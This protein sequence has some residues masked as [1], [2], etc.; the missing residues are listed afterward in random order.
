MID[1]KP[2]IT[3]MQYIFL[4]HGVQ[5]GIGVLTLPRKL[6]DTAGTDGW[7]TIIICW[8]LATIFSLVIIQVM[9]KYPNGTIIDLVSHYFGKW[10]GKI[11]ALIFALYFGLLTIITYI[12]EVLFIQMWIL[13]YSKLFVLVLLIAVPSYFILRN[14]IHILGR[15][16]QFIF[17]MTLWLII[18]Y[19]M[20]LKYANWLHLLPILKEGWTPVVNGLKTGVFSF[21]GYEIAFFLYPYLEQKEKASLGIVI[22]NTISLFFFLTVTI[23]AFLYFSPDEITYYSEPSMVMLKIVEFKFIERLEIVF[24]SFYIFVISTTVLPF[25]YMSVFSAKKFVNRFA[26]HQYVLFFLIMLFLYILFIPPTFDRNSYYQKIAEHAGL[27]IAAIFPL[28]LWGLLL[29]HGR[30]KGRERK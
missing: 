18:I 12:R 8:F 19:L 13:P 11:S 25:M 24:F 5:I 29:L 2:Q 20:P 4:I 15:Y 9:K 21:L 16:C 28:I 7:I 6:A 22:A 14:D 23:I 30:W 17:F 3:F 26:Q 1:R 27:V 10:A